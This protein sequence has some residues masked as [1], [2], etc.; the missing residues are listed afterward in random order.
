MKRYLDIKTIKV[1]NL[2]AEY[3]VKLYFH[4]VPR[5]PLMGEFIRISEIDNVINQHLKEINQEEIHEYTEE[6]RKRDYKLR[7]CF[8]FVSD[9]LINPLRLYLNSY[10]E[11]EDV[12]I[13]DF[14]LASDYY[15]QDLET[16][17]IS[18]Y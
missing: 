18:I 2:V 5:F 4:K 12:C 17:K 16:S 9:N 15:I 10:T 14:S 1:S 13:D 6:V 8:A 7:P 3:M 11:D